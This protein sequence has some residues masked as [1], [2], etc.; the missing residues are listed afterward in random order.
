MSIRVVGDNTNN[1]EV[2]SFQFWLIGVYLYFKELHRASYLTVP[3]SHQISG[4]VNLN[5]L[6]VLCQSTY[7]TPATNDEKLLKPSFYSP[8]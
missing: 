5:M 3:R 7:F 4:L 1:G 6:T 2:M 8:G